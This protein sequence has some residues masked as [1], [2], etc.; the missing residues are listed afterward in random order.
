[1]TRAC[2][3]SA[4]RPPGL[5][6]SGLE[7]VAEEAQRL[8]DRRSSE[9]QELLIQ[10]DEADA[11]QQEVDQAASQRQLLQR[12][13]DDAEDKVRAVCTAVHAV[14]CTA[15]QV[16]GPASRAALCKPALQA[17]PVCICCH[18]GA[19]ALHMYEEQWCEVCWQSAC[20]FAL[21]PPNLQ[22]TRVSGAAA[23]CRLP[24]SALSWLLC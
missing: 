6:F 4:L 22:H 20:K 23:M 14:F 18:H 19:Q 21:M 11:L 1:M 8:A 16:T 15:R 7:A 9:I 5:Q 12:A 17:L 3:L 24:R 13:L 2:L 10:K